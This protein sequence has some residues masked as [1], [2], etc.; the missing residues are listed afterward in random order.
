MPAWLIETFASALLTRAFWFVTLMT[1]PAWIAMIFFPGNN[2]VKAVC[3]PLVAPVAYTMVWAYLAWQAWTL[4]L[5][6]PTGTSF[7][8]SRDLAAHPMVF[9]GGWCQL[10][11]LQL[12]LG[13]WIYQDALKRKWAV[14]AE[15]LACWIFGPLALFIYALR[16]ALTGRK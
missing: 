8:E 15:L 1:S 13:T 4:G 7:Q 6:E 2:W 5:P 10:Q 11:V 14:P 16:V 12:F 9:L 3:R